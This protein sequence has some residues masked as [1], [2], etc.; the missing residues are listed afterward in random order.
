MER[1]LMTDLIKWKEGKYRKPLI[2]WGARQVGKTWLMK[3]FGR[4]EYKNTVY[5]SFYNNKRMADIFEQDYDTSRILNAIEVINHVK[6]DPD[7]TLIVFDEVQAAPK[8]VESLKYFCEDAREYHVVAAGSLLGVALHEGISFPVG[9]VNELRLYP[10]NFREFLAACGEDRLVSYLD[11]PV[12]PQLK[13]FAQEYREL[14]KKYMCVGGM[15]EVVALYTENGDPDEVRQLQ[16][17]IVSQYEG[18]F[19]K[20]ANTVELPRIRM[21]WQSIPMQL[22]KENKKFFFG[23][24]KK[25]ARQKDFEKAIQWLAD[26]GLIYKVHKVSKPAVPLSSYIDFSAFKIF[27]LDTGLLGAMSELDMNSVL[28]GNDIFVE[29]KGAL[30]EQFVLQQLISD[31]DYTPYYYSGEKSTYETDFLV[32]KGKGI[33]PLEVKAETNLRSKSLKVFCDKFSPSEAVRISASD[34]ADQGWMKNIP[35][36]AVCDL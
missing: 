36:W 22:S 33:V 32:Q 4:R 6:I 7:N 30:A 5:I 1:F 11:D 27:V 34:Y 28:E 23:Q 16:N 17:E 2:L 13:E 31:T 9:K 10:L 35:L 24:I 29:F 20:H 14:L 8:V 12:A 19:G 15:P 26:A 21:V 18:D 3:E 25:G